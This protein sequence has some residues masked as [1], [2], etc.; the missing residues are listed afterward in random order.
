MSIKFVYKIL[1]INTETGEEK[2]DE[3]PFACREHAEASKELIEN[4][5]FMYLVER[6]V[7]L[8]ERLTKKEI[9]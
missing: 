9:I 8:E 6:T 7:H 5:K 2:F 4:D 1:S 3:T